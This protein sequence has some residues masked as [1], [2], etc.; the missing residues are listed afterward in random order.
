VFAISDGA[1]YGDSADHVGEPRPSRFDDHAVAGYLGHWKAVLS[2]PEHRL[3][4]FDLDVDAGARP[5][6]SPPPGPEA[7]I[8]TDGVER[9]AATIASALRPSE[10]ST[11]RRL[12][13]WG[14][15]D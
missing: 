3:Q 13:A 5:T 8:L 6:R 12:R 2:L 9:V 1:T 15:A 14:Y 11:D 7:G 4:F 10:S